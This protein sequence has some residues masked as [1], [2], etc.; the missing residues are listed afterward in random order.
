[1]KNLKALFCIFL[2]LNTVHAQQSL[3]FFIDKAKQNSPVLREYTL[4][5]NVNQLQQK[6]NAAENSAFHFSLSGDYIFVP[7]FNND[8]DIVTTNPSADA[9]GYDIGLT[10][11]GLYSAQVNLE[12]NIFNGGLLNVLDQKTHIQNNTFRYNFN[13]QKHN[14]QKQVTDQYVTASSSLQMMRLRQE[15]VLN[16]QEQLKLTGEMVK[17]GYSRSQDYLLLKIELEN[18]KINS[19]DAQNAFHNDLLQLYSICGIAD[20]TIIEII[21][22]ELILSPLADSSNFIKKYILDSLD[23]DNQQQLFE[24][25]YLPQLKF[26]ANAGLNAVE[27]SRIEH[28][29]G[30]SAGLTFSMA[31]LDGNQR[32]LTR[33]QSIINQHSIA[34]YRNFARNNIN[35]Q[36][37]NL[38]SRLQL[39]KKN[40]ESLSKQIADYKTLLDIS[41]GQLE[42]G[43]I[44]MIDYLS[45]LR[46]FNNLRERRIELETNKQ[47]E[48]SNYNYWNW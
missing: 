6:L 34:E 27:L 9:Y 48:I 39:A 5:Q 23:L 19:F 29:F 37:A 20:T 40:I 28:R 41:A 3:E 42:Q 11:G 1:M 35:L 10:D 45:L 13:L 25:K 38:K 22:A 47:L 15:T 7:Y 31:L 4:L 14:L 32:S 26:F 24:T 46:N 36:R 21:P 44:S 17:K 2:F 12:R 8:G 33:Q 43:N 30:M 16:L 18:Q